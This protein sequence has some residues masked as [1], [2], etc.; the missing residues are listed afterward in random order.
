MK[1]YDIISRVKDV[2]RQSEIDSYPVDVIKL[3]HDHGFKVYEQYLP[4]N[5]SGMIMV[6]D[7]KQIDH[8]D[9]NKVIVV[10]KYDYPLRRRFTIAHELAHYFLQ[11]CESVKLYAHR[12]EGNSSPEE[13]DA[14]YFASNLLMPEEMVLQAIQDKKEKVL[15]SLPDS[16]LENMISDEFQVSL[17]AAKV[18]LLQLKIIS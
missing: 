12:D 10:N 4:Q 11:K 8:F 18:R 1:K 2:I 16:I 13:T 6:D 5:V 15:G 9:S 7:D 14:N 17:S 3:A